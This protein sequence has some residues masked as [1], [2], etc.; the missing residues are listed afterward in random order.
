MRRG[1]R[2]RW[3]PPGRGDGALAK[4][5]LLLGHFLRS[6]GDWQE[7]SRP[8]TGARG[9]LVAG[10]RPPHRCIPGLLHSLAL[11][12][13]TPG[14]LAKARER[15]ERDASALGGCRCRFA[16]PR[17]GE[18]EQAKAGPGSGRAPGSTSHLPGP[19]LQYC[20]RILNPPRGPGERH[21]DPDPE[22][23]LPSTS[24]SRPAGGTPSWSAAWPSS[25]A[26]S[27]P[28][29]PSTPSRTQR[30]IPVATANSTASSQSWTNADG[31]PVGGNEATVVFRGGRLASGAAASFF[32][33]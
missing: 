4:G 23:D 9:N 17:R 12:H 33:F 3:W 22:V 31:R 30:T 15:N 29:I 21:D 5:L 11:C 13:E 25:W 1:A 2:S 19:R 18:G 28:Q 7:P 14:D 20:E 16:P 6:R 8:T 10:R 27:S 32:F 24:R 26:P